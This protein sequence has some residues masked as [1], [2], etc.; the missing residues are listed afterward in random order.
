MIALGVFLAAFAL[1][2]FG[3]AGLL[4]IRTTKGFIDVPNERSSHEAPKPRTGGVAIV[5]SFYAVLAI[6]F[7][8]V[9][10]TRSFLPFAL[11]SGMLF[12]TGVV[13]DWRGLGVRLRFAMQLATVL[14]VAAFG[15]VLDHVYIPAVGVVHFGWF[16]VPLTC[17]FVMGSINFYNFVD[18][19]DGLAAGSAFFTSG[20][21]ALIS[22]LL[23]HDYL[24]LV[25]LVAAGS[26]VG[27]L[28][29]NFPPS[30][31]FM[32]DSGSTFLGFF[33]AYAAITGNRLTP[34]LPVFIP[35]LI[36]SS[37]Y[38]DAGLT[39]F[40]RLIKKENIFKA[41][42]THYYQRLLSLGLNHKQVTLLEYGLVI[43]LGISA[44]VYFKAGEYFPVFL[45]A[46]W[47]MLFTLL[48][49]K[50]RG[51]ERGDKLFW[52][53]RTLLV[54]GADLFSITAAYLGAYFLRM[55]FR[56][57]EA[58]GYAVLRA[59]P[60][61]LIV[62]SA[63]F[64]KYGLYKS[65]WKYTSTADVVR[66]IKA[67]TMG[68]AIILTAVV[69]LY[70][71][72]AFPRTLFIIEYVLLTL[73]VLGTRFSLRLF[74]EIGKES[75]GTQVRRVGIVG[76]G[77][78]G[79]RIGRELR[80][81]DRNTTVACYIDD[82]RV[83]IGLTLQGVPITGPISRLKEICREYSLEGIVLGI[84][85]ID[86]KK[87]RAIVRDAREAG[88]ALESR[89]G[90]FSSDAESPA[91]LFDRLKQKLDRRIAP[92]LDET[93][94]PL[95]DGSRVLLTGG[96]GQIGGALARSLA[97]LGAAVA[98]QIDNPNDAGR[99]ESPLGEELEYFPGACL[100]REDFS[101]LLDESTPDVVFHCVALDVGRMTNSDR[102]LWQT[103]VAQPY[104]LCEAL[105]ASRVSTLV[106]LSFWG[107]V[108]PGGVAA[109]FGAACETLVLNHPSLKRISR[110]CVRFPRILGEQDL[111]DLGL[112]HRR[113]AIEGSAYDLLETEAADMAVNT[114]QELGGSIVVP[115]FDRT[116]SGLEVRSA[117]ETTG[118]HAESPSS[119]P[120]N[121][122]GR[123]SNYA[124]EF[125]GQAN[126]GYRT[127]PLFPAE[128]LELCVAR[129]SG[130]VASPIFPMDGALAKVFSDGFLD[131]DPS[132][133]ADW[134]R[135]LTSGLYQITIPGVPT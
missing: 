18:G 129:G 116:F 120:E 112:A 78:R 25:F 100:A 33:F 122:S 19:I 121:L 48:I 132:D 24:A 104:A 46:C 3:T 92:A 75:S 53:K 4:R 86:G 34:E 111:L 135:L 88:I 40:S 73:F 31:L 54:I 51:L 133:R 90:V 28:Q 83:K 15:L 103:A 105:S 59:L 113:P 13:D 87:H 126:A 45:S 38:L 36:L 109:G 2:Y 32:G 27:F 39:L 50:I 23:G 66:I 16:A 108:I 8:A 82:D 56:F 118:G 71:F 43:L 47:L 7:V 134:L 17:L 52:E 127:G 26:T 76:A 65:V 110:K 131:S 89:G 107:K 10:A 29:F 69:L 85:G 22:M 96:G 114:G 84:S 64:F 14:T 35:I 81:D 77:D 79:E 63:C 41:H 44:V 125:L 55:N 67:V 91:V 101:H 60:I 58:E 106:V 12:L 124:A 70:R 98:V 72:I 80:G 115:V 99:F 37:L 30:R 93:A 49:L 6:L 20:F 1:S 130:R 95:F 102:Y 9:P 117:I 57:T 74:H 11:G 123:G 128:R 42:H 119:Q 68:S 97:R 61:V 62:R 5:L 94:R 21:L